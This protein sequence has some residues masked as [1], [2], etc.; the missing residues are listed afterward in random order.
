[1]KTFRTT[2]EE[3]LS[4]ERLTAAAGLDPAL[5]SVID[6]ILK[7]IAERVRAIEEVECML[8]ELLPDSE[9]SIKRHPTETCTLIYSIKKE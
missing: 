1:M 5:T 6:E 9:F 8:L 2:L 7:A 4:P 3:I